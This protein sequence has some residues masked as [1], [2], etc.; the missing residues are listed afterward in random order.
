MMSS[1]R[2]LGRVLALSIALVPAVGLLAPAA[3]AATANG[4]RLIPIE[5]VGEV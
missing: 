3:D 1:R 5:G 2:A 4:K